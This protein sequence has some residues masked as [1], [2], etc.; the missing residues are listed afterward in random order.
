MPGLKWLCLIAVVLLASLSQP[1]H[2]ATLFCP[3][4]IAYIPNTT[5][6]PLPK[7]FADWDATLSGR[8]TRPARFDHV[9]NVDGFVICHYTDQNAPPGGNSVTATG[10]GGSTY[11]YTTAPPVIQLKPAV[12]VKCKNV[13]GSWPNNSCGGASNQCGFTCP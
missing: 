8:P 6:L 13:V 9:T 5:V 12:L 2:A 4:P 11:T 7:G 1:A 3:D 10:S